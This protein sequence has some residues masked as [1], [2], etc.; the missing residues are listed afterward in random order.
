MAKPIAK[1]PPLEG[2]DANFIKAEVNTLRTCFKNVY[3]I[4]CRN[5]NIK[6]RV[7]NNMV[8][9]T[10]EVINF[11]DNVNIEYKDGIILTDNYCPV[12]TLIPRG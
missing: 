10:D 3:I 6:D 12:D 8:I 4:P 9:A 11:E 7:Q 5:K 1:T 2:E